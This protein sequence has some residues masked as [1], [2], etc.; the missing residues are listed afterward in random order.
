MVLNSEDERN[1]LVF[2]NGGNNYEEY[3]EMK[4]SNYMFVIDFFCVSDNN[5]NIKRR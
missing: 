2:V 3:T 1:K 4:N 5:N